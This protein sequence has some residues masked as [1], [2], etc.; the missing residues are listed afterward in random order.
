MHGGQS[1]ELYDD[2][3]ARMITRITSR[4]T[5]SDASLGNMSCVQKARIQF[6]ESLR[7][8]PSVAMVAIMYTCSR[9][10]ENGLPV[11]P[12]HV[13]DLRF[14]N[15]YYHY[16]FLRST[17]SGSS[18]GNQI[19]IISCNQSARSHATLQLNFSLDAVRR[20]VR[21]TPN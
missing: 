15:I 8:L 6:F 7:S 3:R 12:A 9:N 21:H 18:V 13:L 17:T 11:E 4:W 19:S 20:L 14:L 1:T 10:V 5:P 16:L 2:E